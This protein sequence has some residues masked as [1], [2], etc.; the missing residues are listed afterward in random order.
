MNTILENSESGAFTVAP[1]DSAVSLGAREGLRFQFR[2]Q[3]LKR[4]AERGPGPAAEMPAP[5]TSALPSWSPDLPPPPLLPPPSPPQEAP[6][7]FRPG[8][9]RPDRPDRGAQRASLL[10]DRTTER[11]AATWAAGGA[12]GRRARDAGAEP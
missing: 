7:S 5:R 1:R 8:L 6:G 11:S 9:P 10:R 12:G 3:R 2:P 4:E